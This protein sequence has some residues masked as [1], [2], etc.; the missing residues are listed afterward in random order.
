MPVIDGLNHFTI[1][2]KAENQGRALFFFYWQ[3]TK[4][5]SI[6]FALPVIKKGYY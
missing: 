3:M 4:M 1:V 5:L 6:T 2:D